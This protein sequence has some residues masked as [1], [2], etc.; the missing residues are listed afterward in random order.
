MRTANVSSELRHYTKRTVQVPSHHLPYG[1]DM[2]KC[3]TSTALLAPP[4]SLGDG[5]AVPAVRVLRDL[6]PFDRF[7]QIG[8][9]R[10]SR[11][12]CTSCEDGPNA[13][14]FWQ[15]VPPAAPEPAPSPFPPPPQPPPPPPPKHQCPPPLTREEAPEAPPR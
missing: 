5:P 11:R 10:S 1:I 15:R 8:N 13:W 7:Q 12:R 6:I 3:A 14:R 4:P 2:R 9:Q